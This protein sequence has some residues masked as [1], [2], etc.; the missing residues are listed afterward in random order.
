MRLYEKLITL[1][2]SL[3]TKFPNQLEDAV[4]SKLNDNESP[5]RF[6]IIETTNTDLT[7]ELGIIEDP[8]S[9]VESIF[10]YQNRKIENTKNFNTMLLIPTGIGCEIGGHAGDAGTVA[11]LIGSVCDNII[12]H[13]NVVNASDINEMPENTL[14][15]EGSV[16][17][18]LIM[19]TIGLQKVRYNRTLV[20]MD[21]HKDKP[22]THATVNSVNAAQSS[23]GINCPQIIELT[24]PIEMK[25]YLADSGCAVG[26][27]TNLDNF[28][29]IL[30]EHRSQYD[31]VAVTSTIQIPQ[32]LREL[33]YE[34]DHKL[35]NMVNPWGGVEAM[36]THSI[37]MLLNVPTAHSPMETSIEVW[38]YDPGVTD[39]R[40]AAEAISLAYLQC[41]LKGLQKS[42]KI[43]SNPN[44]TNTNTI[45]ARDISVLVIPDGVVGL[46]TLAALHQGI[47][48]IAVREN[49]NIMKNNLTDL[50]WGPEQL[51][52]V[53]N[54]WE[55][56]G[57]LVSI[58]EGINPKTIRRP[59]GQIPVNYISNP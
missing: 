47:P 44:F 13:P 25:A 11:Q 35:D 50:P 55:A 18:R 29:Q 30:K 31:A 54:Y 21:K 10:R 20:I 2:R 41:I 56:V 32:G 51:Y 26:E 48:V 17:T 40:V 8:H 49:K 14:Y 45:T 57:I 58:K 12:L 22:I 5:I 34:S 6:A 38:N 53:D 4:F 3:L 42:P 46:P 37:S 15:V 28:Y 16:L 7:C 43:I 1:K 24:P 59:L 52:L 23:Y 27:V 39:P 33:Y 19:G 36:L 9:S